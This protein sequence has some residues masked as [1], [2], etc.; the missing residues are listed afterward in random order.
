[1]KLSPFNLQRVFKKT[2]FNEKQHVSINIHNL[3]RYNSFCFC[4]ILSV[5]RDKT[6]KAN[7][8]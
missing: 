1:M 6:S 7:K 3:H 2:H 5:G 4:V 8:L